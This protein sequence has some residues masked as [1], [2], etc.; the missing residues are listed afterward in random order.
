M[1]QL[2]DA[3]AELLDYA[4]E[5]LPT[6]EEVQQFVLEPITDWGIAIYIGSIIVEMVEYFDKPTVMCGG[7]HFVEGYRF[8][9]CQCQKCQ[10][11]NAIH[12]KRL[13]TMKT[14]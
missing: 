14:S 13:A 4:L 9:D 2:F 12:E 3:L 5:E 10:R 8:I 1:P 7:V 11:L 6:G